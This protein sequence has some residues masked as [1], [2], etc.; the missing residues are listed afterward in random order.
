MFLNYQKYF[1]L[2]LL[3]ILLCF[4]GIV[5]SLNS[6]GS[7]D[8][9][10]L[11]TIN[12]DLSFVES[13]GFI[14]PTPNCKTITSYYGYRKAP[15][16]GAS[17]YHGGIDIGAP[18]GT[19]IHA[20]FSGEVISTSFNGANGFTVKVSDGT[21]L[22][23]YSHVSPYFLVYV[24]QLVTKGEVIATVGPKNVYGV[25]GNSFKDSNGNPTNGAT[26]GPHL[27]FSLYVNGKSVNPLDYLTY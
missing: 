18:V 5:F 20:V 1:F 7:T 14:W 24:G 21:Y 15:T 2:G 13:E 11:N 4:F 26:T 25:P 22:C 23:N 19:E 17:S 3:F 27:H 12:T 9:N 16:S 8:F 6:I 10:E